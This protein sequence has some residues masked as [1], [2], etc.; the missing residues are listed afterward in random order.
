MNY[1]RISKLI[2][3]KHVR[4]H[5]EKLLYYFFFF[6]GRALGRL[7]NLPNQQK[8][9]G[10]AFPMAAWGRTRFFLLISLN[11]RRDGDSR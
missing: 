7:D 6:Y 11:E 4:I 1:P 10:N 3:V 2:D 8:I 9:L 5:G